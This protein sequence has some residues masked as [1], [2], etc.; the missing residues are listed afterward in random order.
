VIERAA[1]H[2]ERSA[3]KAAIVAP[4]HD[5]RPRAHSATIGGT[6]RQRCV[7]PPSLRLF[8]RLAA[9]FARIPREDLLGPPP[10]RAPS[11]W[12]LAAT[13]VPFRSTCEA[14]ARLDNCRRR[15][16]YGPDV[17]VAIDP[18]RGLNNGQPSGLAIWLQLYDRP[19]WDAAARCASGTRGASDAAAERIRKRYP[20]NWGSFVRGTA[21][22]STRPPSR[23]G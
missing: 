10:W 11:E 18:D 3:A 15:T 14:R 8:D 16:A 19:G 2:R 23:K 6:H 13:G 9:A 5:G 22:F 1:A 12:L 21:R 17:A 20:A 7:A 4:N